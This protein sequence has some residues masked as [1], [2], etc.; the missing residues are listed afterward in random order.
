MQREGHVFF[1]QFVLAAADTNRTAM[2]A[3]HESNVRC[4]IHI[5]RQ[6]VVATEV[7]AGE[8]GVI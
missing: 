2:A 8:V 4:L 6:D 1:E 7:C 5:Q 3:R